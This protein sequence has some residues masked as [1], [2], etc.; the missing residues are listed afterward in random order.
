MPELTKEM[1]EQAIMNTSLYRNR[2]YHNDNIEK[3]GA[4]VKLINRYHSGERT[5]ELYNA[6]T[7]LSKTAW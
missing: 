1:W 5:E 6:M 3:M 7:N 4:A 2:C